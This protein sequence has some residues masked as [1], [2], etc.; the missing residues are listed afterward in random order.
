MSW[1]DKALAIMAGERTA[2]L[3]AGVTDPAAIARAID[4]A[5]PWGERRRTPYKAWLKARSEFFARHGLPMRTRK[6]R[7]PDLFDE[8]TV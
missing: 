2:Q 5:Y 7:Q 1:T 6:R 8:R 4:A 3:L